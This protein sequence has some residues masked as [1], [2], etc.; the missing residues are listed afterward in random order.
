[1]EGGE[2]GTLTVKKVLND[3]YMGPSLMGNV[4]THQWK[5]EE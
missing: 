2:T 4:P 1:M 3:F 5:K